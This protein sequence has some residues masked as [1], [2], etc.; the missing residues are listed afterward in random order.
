[1]NR[2]WSINYCGCGTFLPCKAKI[3]ASAISQLLE[4]DKKGLI[5][6]VNQNIGRVVENRM[7]Q[8]A[9]WIQGIMIIM[10]FA[11][12]W[13]MGFC[14][15]GVRDLAAQW[16]QGSSPTSMCSPK[17]NLPWQFS[18]NRWIPLFRDAKLLPY[19]YPWVDLWPS[20]LQGTW[21]PKLDKSHP[22]PASSQQPARYRATVDPRFR[23]PGQTETL[24]LLE[25]RP[26]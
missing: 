12:A 6:N 11:L 16:V 7:N 20:V 18:V 10:W 21:Q 2:T 13:E 9:H 4:Q 26:L 22:K 8:G 24:D 17:A 23:Q 1:M 3:L 5:Y 19:I 25:T 14:Q 15:R